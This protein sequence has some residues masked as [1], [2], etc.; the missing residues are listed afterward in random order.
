MSTTR[1]FM[2]ESGDGGD[3]GGDDGGDSL[4]TMSSMAE[5]GAGSS[6]DPPARDT[7]GASIRRA[8]AKR[9]NAAAV[10]EFKCD[11]G[12][13]DGERKREEGGIERGR[14]DRKS[15]GFCRSEDLYILCS[16]L[17]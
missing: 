3:Y 5:G 7:A 1:R 4:D 10:G 6:T 15:S 14:S 2:H 9:A 11:R 13:S 16:F 17:F 12:G 8:K